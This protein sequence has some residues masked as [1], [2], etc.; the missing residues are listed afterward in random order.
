MP[1][2]GT[3]AEE[4]LPSPAADDVV[5]R[6]RFTAISRGTETLVFAGLVPPSEYGRMRA[7]FQ[8]GAFPGPVKYGYCN[9]GEVESG[10]S[11]LI[12]RQ[13]FSLYPHQTR[14]VVPAAAVHDVPSSV[15]PERAVLA[16][17]METALNGVWDGDV[18]PGD[19]IA[20]VGGGTV[21]CLVAWLASR[22]PGCDVTL[23]DINP[24]R[25]SIARDLGVPFAA[26][27][28]APRECDVLFHV[29][30]S[31]D[32]LATALTLCAFEATIVEMSWY[33][34]KTVTAPLGEAFHSQR[35]TI[36][37]SQVGHVAPSNR[38]RWTH[39]RRM[40]LALSLLAAPELDALVTGE[41]PFEELPMVMGELASG[42][43]D[44]LCHRIRYELS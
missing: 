12:G 21:G 31:P 8:E 41:S 16:A 25:A 14:F 5:V 27:A 34:S 11:H 44:A 29:S 2:E 1:G 20:V 36:R 9:V 3:I 15:P 37:S 4:I 19:R 22:V 32:G 23:V 7:P 10:P 35:L 17:N 30:G 38:A 24:A 43:R 6:T 26:P 33:G 42:R 13:V 28:R 40:A 18:K 39:R